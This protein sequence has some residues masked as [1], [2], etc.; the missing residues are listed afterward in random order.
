MLLVI[1][2]RLLGSKLAYILVI[3]QLICILQKY[4]SFYCKTYL[5]LWHFKHVICYIHSIST[6][7]CVWFAI[8]D[9]F[10]SARYD[11]FMC[12]LLLFVFLLL[13]LQYKAIYE[14]DCLFELIENKAY[15]L[16]YYWMQ[17]YKYKCTHT[18]IHRTEIVRRWKLVSIK[19][20][21]NWFYVSI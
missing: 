4:S 10:F 3:V 18:H 2:W 12:G 15:E 14:H 20:V 13:L 16:S 17:F 5:L 9:S 8:F 6:F 19:E 11:I 1:S 21:V 7:H